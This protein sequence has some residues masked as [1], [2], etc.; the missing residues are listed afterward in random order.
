MIRIETE[1]NGIGAEGGIRM[2]R[3]RLR[4]AGPAF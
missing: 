4:L 1:L 2:Q 3:S